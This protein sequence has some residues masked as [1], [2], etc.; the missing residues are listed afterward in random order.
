MK[1]IRHNLLGVFL[2]V[3]LAIHVGGYRFLKGTA[4]PCAPRPLSIALV[5]PAPVE[6]PRDAERVPEPFTQTH[7]E[8]GPQRYRP[9]KLQA[10]GEVQGEAE[11]ERTAAA[12]AAKAS[13]S[14]LR[15]ADN[16]ETASLEEN[17]QPRSM[18]VAEHAAYREALLRDFD[19]DWTVI[20]D[21]VVRADS[22]MQQAVSRF[23]EMRLIA[24]PKGQKN[25]S[26]VVVIDE[27]KGTFEYTRDFDFTRY[28]NRAKDRS[29]LPGYAQLARRMKSRLGLPEEL[30]V[31]SLVP[32]GADA[33]FAAKQ[34]EA[35]RAA[36]LL[37]ADVSRTEG[38]Y[39]R[40][41]ADRYCL[42]VETVFHRN[43]RP[44]NVT[45]LEA[46]AVVPQ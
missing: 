41:A 15:K 3:S 44:V 30:V 39:A 28:S 27:E 32:T 11:P 45:D 18:S 22:E 6:T 9:T 10:E 16:A 20:P 34:M 13:D 36:G 31:V 46:G 14:V 25:P 12:E 42:I 7:R 19:P 5:Q 2:V 1:A 8:T 43:G 24:Y 35:I 40:D 4:A 29:G 38:C 17:R 33:Y 21:L 37:P 23:F 26:Y